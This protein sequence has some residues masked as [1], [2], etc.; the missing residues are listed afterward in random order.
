[1]IRTWVKLTS[2]ANLH[3]RKA[4]NRRSSMLNSGSGEC[5]CAWPWLCQLTWFSVVPR[6]MGTMGTGA[7]EHENNSLWSTRRDSLLSNLMHRAVSI[8]W[9][10]QCPSLSCSPMELG[11]P[12]KQ[13]CWAN[14]QHLFIH[15]YMLFRNEIPKFL[16]QKHFC[17]FPMYSPGGLAVLCCPHQAF[18]SFWA[19]LWHLPFRD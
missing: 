4:R 2:P 12:Q 1:M 8:P 17:I 7:S 9:G 3:T 14:S 19:Q 18:L 10:I 6:T 16:P 11:T 13:D 5:H 15:V